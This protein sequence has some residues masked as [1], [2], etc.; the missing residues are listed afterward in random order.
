MSNEIKKP[1]PKAGVPALYDAD[2]L[3]MSDGTENLPPDARTFPFLKIAQ[4]KTAQAIKPTSTAPNPSYIAGL[5]FGN[6]FNSNSNRNYGSGPLRVIPVFCY[7]MYT[8]WGK[9]LGDFKGNMLPSEFDA[10]VAA[11]K[12]ALNEKRQYIQGSGESLQRGVFTRNF[13]LLLPD[14]VEAGLVLLSLSSIGLTQARKWLSNMDRIYL[15]EPAP[16]GTAAK[17]FLQIWKLSTVQDVRPSGNSYQFGTKAKS[18]IEFDSLV[19]ADMVPWIRQALGQIQAIGNFKTVAV[20]AEVA[21]AETGTGGPDA[22]AED[23]GF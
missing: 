17:K 3:N 5:E 4:E 19:T 22:T 2:L 11:G 23:P 10:E 13:F 12:W 8:I 16:A 7:D 9:N 20:D 14:D 21:H 18:C 15:P 6:L 1:D